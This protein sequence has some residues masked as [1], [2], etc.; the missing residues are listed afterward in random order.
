MSSNARSWIRLGALGS[1]PG[2]PRWARA[3]PE[4]TRGRTADRRLQA[5]GVGPG[6]VGNAQDGGDRL[7]VRV[8][9]VDRLRVGD[10][11]GPG[12]GQRPL[13]VRSRCRRWPTGSP[14]ARRST[15]GCA[16]SRAT[17]VR[18]SAEPTPSFVTTLGARH[19]HGHRHQRGRAAARL[20]RRRVRRRRQRAPARRGWQAARRRRRPRAAPLRGARTAARSPACASRGTWRRSG[21][22]RTDWT[23]TGQ[24]DLPILVRIDR[25]TARPATGSRRARSLAPFDACPDP[26][27]LAP[28]RPG[29]H[30]WRL[31]SLTN[32]RNPGSVS[33]SAPPMRSLEG[34]RFLGIAGRGEAVEGRT[35]MVF[36]G[37]DHR[38]AA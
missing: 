25:T 35:R 7:L 34:R 14:R 17:V 23:G 3:G 38:R 31:E 2:G 16:R 24:P 18:A 33:A 5:R 9:P 20:C 22:R 32:D 27:P 10:A 19:G 36:L 1:A 21:S 4:Q 15:T 6:S 29:R 12:H 37:G 8:R 13:C 28:R 11:S 30:R 26:A